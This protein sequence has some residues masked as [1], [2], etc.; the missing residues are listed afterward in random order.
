MRQRICDWCCLAGMVVTLAGYFG[1]TPAIAAEQVVWK[2]HLL[3]GSLSV[4][5]LT[6]LATTGEVSPTIRAYLTLAG[7]NP[8]N[9]RETL[10]HEVALDP[11]LLS[12]IVQSPLGNL[13][14]NQLSRAIYT[15]SRLASEEAMRS[16]LVL[17]ASDDGH[18]SLMEIIQKYPANEVY[19]DG[20]RLATA[21]QQ[22]EHLQ[23]TVEQWLEHNN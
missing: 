23:T 11:I 6:Q 13:I 17:S 10:S 1:V 14:L 22:I 18:L 4:E 3:Q 7:R 8:E 12:H 21:Y 16:A 15:P 9:V 19:V 20:D 5:E 2:Y